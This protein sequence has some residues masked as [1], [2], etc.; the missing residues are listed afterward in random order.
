MNCG[1][2]RTTVGDEPELV[3]VGMPGKANLNRRGIFLHERNKC[4]VKR[5][6]P[7]RHRPPCA[8][9]G[10]ASSLV[11]SGRLMVDQPD[12]F[13]FV[14]RLRQCLFEPGE[15]G[16]P[17][18]VAPFFRRIEFAV[19]VGHKGRIRDH[20]PPPFN[21]RVRHVVMPHRREV[22]PERTGNSP[23]GHV[24]L[25]CLCHQRQKLLTRFHIIVSPGI[26]VVAERDDDRRFGEALVKHPRH[27]PHRLCQEPEVGGI[28]P[29]SYCL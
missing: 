28:A 15:F 10:D 1:K 9:V 23:L 5:F 26:V 18:F 21:R 17:C 20:E 3:A 19:A 2:S 16:L 29:V 25:P 27:E 13:S 7:Y 4:S 22:G 8:A 24:P 12:L 11:R 6:P 14:T